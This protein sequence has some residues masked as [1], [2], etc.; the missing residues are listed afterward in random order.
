M[1]KLIKT[2]HDFKQNSF[3]EPIGLVPTMG[4]LHEGHFSLINAAKKE[5]STVIVYIFINPLQFGEGENYDIYPRDLDSDIEKCKKINVDFVFAP[6]TSEIF[7]DA[8]KVKNNLI[9]PPSE[10][11]SILCGKTRINHFDG[12]ATV[13]KRFLNIVNP[14]NVYFGKKDLQQLYI[15]Y[16]LIK[17]FKLKTIVKDCPIVREKGGLAYSSRNNHLDEKQKEIASNIY[18]ALKLAKDNVRSG[19]FSIQESILESLVHLTK[20][21]DIKVEYFEARNKNDLT[22]VNGKVQSGFYFLT[23]CN[24]GNVRLIDNIEV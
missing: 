17:E 6:E 19:M 7:P 10:L 11:S 5:C 1:T 22:E 4:A 13:V 24:V 14:D 3:N 2:I 20:H 12:V 9:K 8:N 23:A 18:K 15:I 16:W 21:S